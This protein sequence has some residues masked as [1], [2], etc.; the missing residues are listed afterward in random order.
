MCAKEKTHLRAMAFRPLLKLACG[1]FDG[2]RLSCALGCI[3]KVDWKKMGTYE[4]V[5]TKSLKRTIRL[6]RQLK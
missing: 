5:T 3:T 4:E 1:I 6:R 2:A